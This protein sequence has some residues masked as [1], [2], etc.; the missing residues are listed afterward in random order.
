MGIQGVFFLKILQ[1][2]VPNLACGQ[3]SVYG[4]IMEI[5]ARAKAPLSS[6]ENIT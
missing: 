3:H 2:L 4:G 5:V 1:N 6:Q